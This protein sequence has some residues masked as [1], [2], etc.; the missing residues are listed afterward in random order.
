MPEVDPSKPEKTQP[1]LGG[2]RIVQVLKNDYR[3]TGQGGERRI[4]LR[5]AL[6][7]GLERGQIGRRVGSRE[8]GK[9]FLE[10]I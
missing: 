9:P 6:D 7:L 5:E 8:S 3:G 1:I 10:A 2:Y 4:V